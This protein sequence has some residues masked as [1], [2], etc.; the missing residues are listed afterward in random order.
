[1]SG[2]GG[3]PAAVRAVLHVGVAVQVGRGDFGPEMGEFSARLHVP[4]A[5]G[6]I[7]ADR[8]HLLAVRTVGHGRRRGRVAAEDGIGPSGGQVVQVSLI[9]VEAADGDL[10]AGGAEGERFDGSARHGQH[11]GSAVE[12]AV[13][14]VPFPAAV[15]R[16][17]LFEG[18]AG[19]PAV[20][21]LQ[22]GGGGG[23][24]RA[25]A[26]PAL[27]VA[28]LLRLVSGVALALGG[29]GL[30]PAQPVEVAGGQQ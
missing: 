26:P 2:G 7:I 9:V 20:L 18:A 22:G 8:G 16:R 29:L 25:V 24:V 6:L 15:L 14:V 19:G 27:G 4:K 1:P 28:G 13:E 10:P 3:N 21:Q 30:V 17:R 5:E 12:L 11:E 23:D